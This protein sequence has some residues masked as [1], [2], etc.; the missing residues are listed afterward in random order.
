VKMDA[1]HVSFAEK[2]RAKVSGKVEA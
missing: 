2:R 1:D